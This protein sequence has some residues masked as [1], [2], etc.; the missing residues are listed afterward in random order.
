MQKWFNMTRKRG[1]RALFSPAILSQIRI[2][3][4]QGMGPAEIAKKI[5]C[6]LGTLRVKCSQGG[7]S[8][9]RWPPSAVARKENI[10]KRLVFSLSG[11]VAAR[12]QQHADE[13][14][15]T[16]TDFAAALLEAIVRDNLYDAVIDSN[17]Q[18]ENCTAS[19]PSTRRPKRT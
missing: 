13:R 10:P 14:G 5:G 6:T 1:A 12:F 11:K 7:I 9:R 3:F 18:A 19:R 17:I 8:L 15:I 4:A 16:I 2:L